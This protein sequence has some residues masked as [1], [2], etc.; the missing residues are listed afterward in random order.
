METSSTFRISVRAMTGTAIAIDDASDADTV[1]SIKE[2]VFAVNRTLPVRRQRL[3][4]RPGPRG[5]EPLADDETLG[6]AGIAKDGS[7]ELDLLLFELSHAEAQELGPKLLEAAMNGLVS[8][9][10]ALLVE[11]A[12]IQF[13]HA[14]D[15]STALMCASLNGHIDCVRLLIESGANTN[16]QNDGGA[17]AL[18]FAAR[19]GHTKCARLLI[20]SGANK[21]AQI[22]CGFTALMFA[23]ANGRTECA[24]LLIDAG[25]DKDSK[26]NDGSTAL[27]LAVLGGHADCARLLFDAGAAAEAKDRSGKSALDIAKLIGN[28]GI[29][30][31][32]SPAATLAGSHIPAT[33]DAQSN[34]LAIVTATNALSLDLGSDQQ[35]TS[36]FR[37]SVRAMT[38]TAIAIDDASDTDTILSIKERV[39]AVNRTMPV[40]RQRLMYCPGPRGIDPL[41]DDETLGGAGVA[42]DGLAELDVVLAEL[43]HAEAQELGPNLLEAA[44]NGHANDMLEVLVEGVNMEFTDMDDGDS[45]LIWASLNGHID[46]VRLL[47]EFGAN[48]DAKNIYGYTALIRAAQKGHADCVRLLIESGANTNAKGQFGFTALIVAA[49]RGH[50]D[51]MRLLIDGKADKD[52]K[53][54]YGHT[55]LI[56]AARK[57][58][59][60]CVRLLIDAGADKHATESS[61]KTALEFAQENGSADI[62]FLLSEADH[63]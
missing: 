22:E 45:A 21:D 6:G 58:H 26:D 3:M 56:W 38:G 12:N 23:A 27:I 28:A 15:E 9:M 47:V 19:N 14:D 33:D 1:R 4:Y 51:C 48:M 24:R 10:L 50:M 8:D 46:C 30:S 25:A 60:E 57:G 2:R 62:V 53:G 54:E 32:L 29:V 11:G 55:A 39:F 16:S 43:S 63:E 41:A 59:A 20:N 40:R 35:S 42:Q 37:I 5:I 13:K 34:E 31:L 61:G 17:T 44:K 18:L 49:A 52:A 7:A 36:T